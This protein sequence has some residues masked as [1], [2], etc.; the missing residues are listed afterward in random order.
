M[1]EGWY[2]SPVQGPGIGRAIALAYDRQGASIVVTDID[3]K[4][5]QETVRLIQE[6]IGIASHKTKNKVLDESKQLF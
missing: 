5:G 2:W 4:G 6:A 1:T 3:V